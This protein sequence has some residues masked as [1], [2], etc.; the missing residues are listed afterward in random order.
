[1][2]NKSF[3]GMEEGKGGSPVLNPR[4]GQQ[5]GG[6]RGGRGRGPG[7]WEGNIKGK[8]LEVGRPV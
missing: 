8:K 3:E 2:E 5:W 7:G 1:M 6:G 4:K